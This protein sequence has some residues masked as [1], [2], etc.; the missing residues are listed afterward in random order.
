MGRNQ[1][2]SGTVG[3]RS[4]Q[5]QDCSSV[6]QSQSRQ[7]RALFS[8]RLI[9]RAGSS[10]HWDALRESCK[11]E[12]TA[13]IL[14]TLR[15]HSRPAGHGKRAAGRLARPPP[16]NVN[17][18]ESDRP[19]EDFTHIS[20]RPGASGEGSSD[21]ALVLAAAD[22]ARRV[23]GMQALDP[24][25][26]PGLSPAS[27]LEAAIS[28]GPTRSSTPAGR[29][30]RRRPRPRAHAVGAVVFLGHRDVYWV[31]EGDVPIA[32]GRGL[33]RMPPPTDPSAGTIVA[34]AWHGRL[35]RRDGDSALRHALHRGGLSRTPSGFSPRPSGGSS[36]DLPSEL[37]AP[38]RA[39]SVAEG[40]PRGRAWGGNIR[41][42]ADVAS[43]G[44]QPSSNRM[45]TGK[46]QREGTPWRTDG[47]G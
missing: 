14:V 19:A 8:D 32:I 17:R 43:S 28:S 6:R 20:R 16:E 11:G 36:E 35:G 27:W 40:P 30:P 46:P 3:P 26:S 44:L 13:G 22:D 24:K 47:A 21:A 12:A 42:S 41:P 25:P 1:P 18:G 29:G 9:D 33:D 5:G 34:S 4:H 38:V 39:W 45:R 23:T 37:D 31:R 7:T 10:G 15:I 2:A